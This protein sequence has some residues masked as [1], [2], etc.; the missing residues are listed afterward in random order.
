[1]DISRILL[2][3]QAPSK[4][5]WQEVVMIA[6]GGILVY[7]AI[8]KDIEPVLLLPIGF[9]AII[10]NVPLNDIFGNTGFLKIIY[11]AGIQT[12]LLPLLLFVGVGAMTD[13]GPLYENPK[14]VFLGAAGHIGVFVTMLVAILF[15]FSI[16]DA[17]AIAAIGTMDG[18]TSIIV[19]KTLSPN[20][21]APIAVAAYSYMSLVPIIQPP[22]M[23]LLTTDAE[24]KTHMPYSQ[25][26][27]SK[28]VRVIFPIAVTI[29]VSLIA[30]AASALIATIM[31]GNLMR[32]SGVVERLSNA[33]ENEIANVCTL[34]LG[35]AVGASMK[36][37]TFIQWN[38]FGVVALGLV[39]FVFDMAGGTLFAKLL[40]VIT[41]HQF[42]PLIGSAGI[43]AFPM[44]A[45]VVQ[46]IGQEYDFDNFLLMHAMGANVAG[47]LCSVVAG[48]VILALLSGT[49][50]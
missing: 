44:A 12:E 20:L 28:T 39:A 42:N 41:H 49:L 47:Q 48:G 19:A 3:I 14:M 32:E 34:L 6:I 16:K 38:T 36:A 11:D 7:L 50:L 9:G 2:L 25:M 27:V 40:Y 35:L 21:L 15:G 5:T 8:A 31:L 18:P 30:P 1:M 10:T 45:R 13:F 17:G 46:R 26:K 29:V 24:R 43:S 4:F 23:R 22:I 37:N 33:S